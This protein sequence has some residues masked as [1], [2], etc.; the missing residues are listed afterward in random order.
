MAQMRKS[1]P[2]KPAYKT[3]K[4]KPDSNLEKALKT[5]ARAAAS[6]IIAGV[7]VAGAYNRAVN[8]AV[9]SVTKPKPKAPVKKST[10]N[11]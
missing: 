11:K 7:K 1:G 3:K 5:T 10:R 9:K 6:P 8:N 4:D 2:A